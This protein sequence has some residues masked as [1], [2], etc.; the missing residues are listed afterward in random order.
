MLRNVVLGIACLMVVHL[1]ALQAFAQCATASVVGSV[2]DASEAAVSRGDRAGQEPGHRCRAHGGIHGSGLPI[3]SNP[4]RTATLNTVINQ[5]QIG[6]AAQWV[7]RSPV[8]AVD[9]RHSRRS[10]QL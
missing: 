2:L 1:G 5:K 8:D 6:L 9:A 7:Q 10:G 4:T 3:A